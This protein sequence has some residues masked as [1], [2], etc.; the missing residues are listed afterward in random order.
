[1]RLTERLLVQDH[2][3]EL[4]RVQVEVQVSHRPEDFLL[5]LQL[6]VCPLPLVA[7]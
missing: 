6:E 5:V 4:E 7:R 3:T 2:L 1:V